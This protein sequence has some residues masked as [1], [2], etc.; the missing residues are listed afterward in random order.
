MSGGSFFD[1]QLDQSRIK[2]LI[3]A[4][5]FWVYVNIIKHTAKKKRL[6]ILIYLPV[7]DVMRM[8]VNPPR[9]WF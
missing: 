7:R 6:P 5:Y 9:Y 2:S 1:E 4:D 3:V 8:G